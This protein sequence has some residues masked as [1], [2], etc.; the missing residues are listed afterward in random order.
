MGL[1]RPRRRSRSRRSRRPLEGK[2]AVLGSAQTGSSKTFAFVVPLL[3]KLLNEQGA[4]AQP[5][6]PGGGKV[7]V[8]AIILVPTRELAA[9]VETAVRD[10]ARFSP[11]Q[12]VLV[13]GGTSFHMQEQALREERR[14]RRRDPRAPARP[15]PAGHLELQGRAHRGP[16]RGRPDVLDMGFMPDIRRIMQSSSCASSRGP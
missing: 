8:K 5:G 1:H 13:I 16:G 4:H 14:D 3:Q 11:M 2:D 9:Q 7:S 15:F 12:C 6:Q 10:L